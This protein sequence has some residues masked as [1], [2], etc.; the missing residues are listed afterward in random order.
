MPNLVICLTL[1]RFAFFT[2]RDPPTIR[3]KVNFRPLSP[4]IHNAI[5]G[6]ILICVKSQNQ[7]AP[8]AG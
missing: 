4:A 7:N 6:S 8:G 3:V 5:D 1:L 2:P